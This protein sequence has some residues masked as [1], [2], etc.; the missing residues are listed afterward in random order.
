MRK[1][2][3]CVNMSPRAAAKTALHDVQLIAKSK[4]H[5]VNYTTIGWAMRE[6]RH[7]LHF[8]QLTPTESFLGAAV[9]LQPFVCAA[10][11]TVWGCGIEWETFHRLSLQPCPLK[12][13][14][15]P[16][17]SGKVVRVGRRIVGS[18][19][20]SVFGQCSLP[21]GPA[22]PQSLT[23]LCMSGW[24]WGDCEASWTRSLHVHCYRGI[25]GIQPEANTSVCCLRI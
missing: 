8:C 4:Y 24:V 3:L 13:M 20:G 21:I 11:S 25:A 19:P 2:R 7:S 10:R 5:L 6:R 17:P 9:W 1:R 16:P 14:C 18:N 22:W 12:P 15:Q 23:D